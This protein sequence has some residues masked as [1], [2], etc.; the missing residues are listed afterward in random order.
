MSLIFTLSNDGRTILDKNCLKLI[1]SMK[2]LSDDELLFLILAIDYHS[3]YNK[4]PDDE[5]YRKSKHQVYGSI[6]TKPW[7]EPRIQT[8][9]ADYMSLQ[10]DRRRELKKTFEQKLDMLQNALLIENSA[11]KITGMLSSMKE[12]R[13]NISDLEKEILTGI[14]EYQSLLEGKGS[15]SL[16]ETM[17]ISRNSFA[18]LQKPEQPWIPS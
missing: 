17:Q 14:G 13:K 5:R 9:M 1:P 12:L 7:E 10:Y 11:P 4:F 2:Y 15:R 8:A 3:P 16:I 18:N 6:D